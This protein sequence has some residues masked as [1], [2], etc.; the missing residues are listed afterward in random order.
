[1]E[2]V[3]GWMQRWIRLSLSKTLKAKIRKTEI[4]LSIKTAFE[5]PNENKLQ[6][7]KKINCKGKKQGVVWLGPGIEKSLQDYTLVPCN[8]SSRQDTSK[9]TNKTQT[10]NLN[11]NPRHKN[12]KPNT[13]FKL[14][15]RT[16]LEY[17]V[18]LPTPIIEITYTF[19]NLN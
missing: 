17:Y 4:F 8:I 1:M 5:P 9:Q 6:V 16:C 3:D 7:W 14:L 10:Q 11:T 2:I 13:D 15:A 19:S 18:Q 12:P